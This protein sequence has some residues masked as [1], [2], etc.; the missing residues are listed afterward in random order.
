MKNNL[1]N[2]FVFIKEWQKV[3]YST[4]WFT[5][6]IPVTAGMKL[7][8]KEGQELLLCLSPGWQEVLSIM[9]AGSWIRSTDYTTPALGCSTLDNLMCHKNA[10]KLLKK[11]KTLLKHCELLFSM[12]KNVYFAFLLDL[13]H[14][15]NG[16][17]S[18]P[19]TF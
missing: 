1:K 16:E 8:W 9:V 12:L 6:Q 5:C 2:I 15:W 4:L 18:S 11:K 17:N 7:D 3:G 13:R 10:S 14:S 19:F